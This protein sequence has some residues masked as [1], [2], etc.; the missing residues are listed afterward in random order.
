MLESKTHTGRRCTK[1]IVVLIFLFSVPVDPILSSM[2]VLEY[3]KNNHNGLFSSSKHPLSK[4]N[5]RCVL[6]VMEM[7][8]IAGTCKYYVTKNR[9][10]N[11]D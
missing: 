7:A 2:A 3:L 10:H 8:C 4:F 11:G 9:A 6:I 5:L 1:E